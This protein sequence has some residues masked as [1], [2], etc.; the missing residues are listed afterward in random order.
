LRTDRHPD[1]R[2]DTR[3]LG[4]GEAEL[5]EPLQA[6]S[7]SLPAAECSNVKASGAERCRDGA[8]VDLGI[9]G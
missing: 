2:P 1:R 8:I 5:L 3:Q 9:V 4:V 7:V 6:F